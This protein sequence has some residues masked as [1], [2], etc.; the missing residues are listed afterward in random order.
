MSNYVKKLF[1]NCYWHQ[2]IDKYIF[3]EKKRE[4][5]LVK[6]EPL[7]CRSFFNEYLKR[8]YY[9]MFVYIL[10]REHSSL[11]GK[12]FLPPKLKPIIEGIKRAARAWSSRS[13]KAITIVT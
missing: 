13:G 6:L 7:Y 5:I 1:Q 3:E 8:V 11:K 12:F 10:Q 9:I 2:I 4:N